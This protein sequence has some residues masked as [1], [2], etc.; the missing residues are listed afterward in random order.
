MRV[1]LLIFFLVLAI[2]SASVLSLLEFWSGQSGSALSEQVFEIRRGE[3]ALVVATNLEKAGIVRNRFGFLYALARLKKLDGGM[4]AGE[5]RLAPEV[6]SRE[7][8]LRITTGQTLS[9]DIRVTFP[10]GFTAL[11]MADRL[12]EA[13]L[14]GEAFLSLVRKPKEEWRSQFSFLQSVT[15]EGGLEGF[16]FPDTYRFDRQ[17]DAERIV[18]VMLETFEK[19]AWPLLSGQT[20]SRAYETLILSSIVETEVRSDRDRSFVAGIFL[21]RLSIGQPLQSDATVKYVLG[22]NK[23]QHSFEETRTDSPYNTYIHKGLPPG[24]IS[25]PGLS[26]ITATLNPA[27]N[28]TLYFLSDPKTGETIFANTFEEHVRNKAAHGL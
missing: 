2:G 3:N 25:N 24:P 26:A 8:A 21:R 22:L 4:V 19:K 15:L 27:Q 13:G 5:Y 20:P 18:E 12:T 16:L 11:Q 28:D 17:V 7:I 10:E 14:P 23:I 6:S 9:R 1:F